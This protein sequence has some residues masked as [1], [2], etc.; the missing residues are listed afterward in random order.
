MRPI[1]AAYSVSGDSTDMSTSV[2]QGLDSALVIALPDLPPV[3]PGSASVD[4]L[5]RLVG[6]KALSLA[7]MTHHGLP[8]PEAYVVTT[9]AYSRMLAHPLLTAA[10]AAVLAVA[11]EEDR[12]AELVLV[13]KL[14]EEL[15]L[16]EDVA[17]AIVTGF[18]TLGADAVA[19]RSSGTAED[20]E[21]ASFA[22][23]YETYLNITDEAALLRAL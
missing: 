18:R 9:A 1:I 23:Q 17:A 11:V 4:G 2:L 10:V 8:V 7:D 14:L 16:P 3:E 20:M 19:V 6:R 12:T 5:V 13:R 21:Q 15:P 22:G